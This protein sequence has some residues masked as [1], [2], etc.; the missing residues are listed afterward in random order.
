VVGA[1]F[2]P[3]KSIRAGENLYLEFGSASA[4]SGI[5]RR[6]VAQ[7]LQLNFHSSI[8]LVHEDV[9]YHQPDRETWPSSRI[10]YKGLSARVPPSGPVLDPEARGFSR[11]E[12]AVGEQAALQH[13]VGGRA[14][15][16]RGVREI[17]GRLFNFSEI[18]FEDCDPTRFCGP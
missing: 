15:A 11:I 4:L 5:R 3:T 9:A 12:R 18:I 10:Q 8:G 17:E 1:L 14:D 16:R 7:Q 2:G 13:L 6:L